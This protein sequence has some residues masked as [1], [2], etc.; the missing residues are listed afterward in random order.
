MKSHL[1][2]GCHANPFDDCACGEPMCDASCE[3]EDEDS[4]EDEEPEE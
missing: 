3:I 4:D 2:D 1:P